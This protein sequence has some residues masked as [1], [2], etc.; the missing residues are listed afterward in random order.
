MCE[1]AEDPGEFLIHVSVLLRYFFDLQ[2][3]NVETRVMIL[4]FT[5]GVFDCTCHSA[6]KR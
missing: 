6:Q 2:L 4:V 5:K 3:R 1:F